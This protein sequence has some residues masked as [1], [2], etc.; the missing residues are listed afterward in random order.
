MFMALRKHIGKPEIELRRLVR[1]RVRGAI[2]DHLR[3]V[4]PLARRSRAA[5]ARGRPGINSPV[6][7]EL[8]ERP[9]SGPDPHENAT[10]AQLRAELGRA[11]R[12]LD[13]RSVEILS[14][15]YCRGASLAEVAARVGLSRS[16]VFQLHRQAITNLRARLEGMA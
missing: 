15:L 5:A 10:R 12:E 7:V 8:R 13:P 6:F 14:L 9:A 16:R 2:L 3:A 4:D 1:S 11:L